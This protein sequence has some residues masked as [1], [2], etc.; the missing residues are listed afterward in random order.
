[1]NKKLFFSALM[2]ISFLMRSQTQ[3]KIEQNQLILSS[4]IL[5]EAGS[6]KIKL[7][8]SKPSLLY[9]KEFLEAKPYI[10]LIRIESHSDNSG[11]E[12]SNQQLTSGRSK[13]VYDWLIANSVDCKKLIAVSFGS[14]KPIADNST[15]EGKTQNRRLSIFMAELRDKAI[16]GMPVDGGGTLSA[17]CR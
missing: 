14:T 3:F 11:T 6:N 7:E 16:G 4:P 2:F 12:V 15:A 13:A 8:E 17:T 10:S 9:I 5:F 1:M